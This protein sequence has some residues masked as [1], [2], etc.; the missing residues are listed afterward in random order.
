MSQRREC[1]EHKNVH[2]SD[3]YSNG[4]SIYLQLM[5]FH[6]TLCMIYTYSLHQIFYYSFIDVG[7]QML[8]LYQDG[9]QMLS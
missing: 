8:M 4:C 6:Y 3:R 5:F 1:L 2:V 7:I 9:K